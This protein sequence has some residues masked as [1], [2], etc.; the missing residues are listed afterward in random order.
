MNR[1]R[2]MMGPL[3]ASLYASLS[4]NSSTP[5]LR[6]VD[7]VDLRRYL[8][9]WYEISRYPNYFERGCVA[10][11]ASYSLMRTGE[12]RVVNRCRIG[13]LD[14]EEVCVMGR[15][16][17]ATPVSN[18]KLAVSFFGPF[19]G[20]YWIIDLADDYTWAVVGHPSRRYLWV[21]SRSPTLP[22]DVYAGILERL[23][24]QCYDTSQLLPTLQPANAPVMPVPNP[25][26]QARFN[27]ASSLA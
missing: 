27:C 23:E 1:L 10:T 16:R 22:E 24:A 3:L 14:G 25:T 9:A 2:D 17:V 13:S 7:Y 15:A 6:T 4:G 8:G 21:L 18:A 19:W 12:I 5:P 20:A 11:M 26:A